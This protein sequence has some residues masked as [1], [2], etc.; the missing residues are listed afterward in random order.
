M[1]GKQTVQSFKMFHPMGDLPIGGLPLLS[2][3]E[4]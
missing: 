4:H 3:D 1:R 2:H